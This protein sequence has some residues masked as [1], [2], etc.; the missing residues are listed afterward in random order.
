MSKELVDSAVEFLANDPDAKSMEWG[1]CML[2]AGALCYT[3]MSVLDD[4]DGNLDKAFR[5]QLIERGWSEPTKGDC[6]FEK[7][8]SV[9]VNPFKG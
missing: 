7:T 6:F 1:L 9:V 4:P 3:D 5:A 8:G 2:D